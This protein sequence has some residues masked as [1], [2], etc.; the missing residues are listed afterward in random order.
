MIMV[1]KAYFFVKEDKEN[2]IQYGLGFECAKFDRVNIVIMTPQ[3]FS[4]EPEDS[5]LKS[6]NI[7]KLV[8]SKLDYLFSDNPIQKFSQNPSL[9]K[10][11]Y[12]PTGLTMASKLQDSDLFSNKGT[13]SLFI[14]FSKDLFNKS[15]IHLSVGRYRNVTET[16]KPIM[17]LNNQLRN[18]AFSIETSSENVS[19]IINKSIE[20]ISCKRSIYD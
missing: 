19:Q 7:Q 16:Y 2:T 3:D 20:M 10:F 1:G 17:M 5:M 14:V 8:E 13:L 9:Y 11:Y 4:K 12:Y 6:S 15:L 18:S